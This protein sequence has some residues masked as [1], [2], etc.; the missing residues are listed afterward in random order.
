MKTGIITFH[1]SYNYGSAL[2][3]YA[4]QKHLADCGHSPKIINY[5]NKLN[6][7]DYRLFRT[8]RYIKSP[9]SLAGDICFLPKNLKRKKAF[10]GFWKNYFSLTESEYSDAADMAGLNDAFEAFICGSDQIWNINCTKGADPAFFLSFADEGKRKIAYAPSIADSSID[11]TKQ[12]EVINYLKRLDYISVREKSFA[13]MVEAAS[14]KPVAA[15]VDP[16]LLLDANDYQAIIKAPAGIPEK[17]IFAFALGDG[18]EVYANAKAFGKEKGLPVVYIEKKDIAGLDCNAYGAAPQE[19]LW[20]IKNAEYI[21][22]NS[23]HA[24]VFSVLFEKRFCTVIMKDSGSRMVDFL[25]AIGLEGRLFS[26]GFD[27]D[28][29]DD[30][31]TAKNKIEA[32][33]KNSKAFLAE[34]L[35]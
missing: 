30:F 22:T 24:T 20:L 15:A 14:G 23:F 35:S 10:E 9:K 1:C 11:F 17:F 28:A 5:K 26:E 12:P 19:F 29:P 3:A 16:T 31:E 4:L 25:G 18:D 2:Q 7:D 27:F 33:A 6:F 32:L 34:A 8:Q 21:I 13:P